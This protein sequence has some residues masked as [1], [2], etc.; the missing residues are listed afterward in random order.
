MSS[1]QSDDARAAVE[2]PT[3]ELPLSKIT[4][5]PEIYGS[6]RKRALICCVSGCKDELMFGILSG[7][8]RT[9][10]R[11]LAK[12]GEML[13]V[14]ERTVGVTR[15]LVTEFDPASLSGAAAKSAVEAFAELEKLGAAGKLLAAARLD[16]TSA[17]SDG[18][19]HRDI[20]GFLALSAGTSVGAARSAMRAARRVK[21]QPAVEA[22]LRHGE[23]SGAQTEAITA[24]VKADPEAEANLLGVAKTAGHR[25]LRRECDRVT[26]AARSRETEAANDERIHRERSLRHRT[27]ADGSGRIEIQGP[28]DRTAQIM[29]GLEPLERELFE[30]NRAAKQLV[31][32]DSVAFDALVELCEHTSDEPDS[33]RADTAPGAKA[34]PAKTRGSR[35][36]AV[37]MVHIS[38]DAYL[39][40]WTVPGEICELEGFGPISVA[41]AYRFASDAF[42]KTVAALGKTEY[43]HQQ[44]NRAPPK[45]RAAALGIPATFETGREM[46]RQGERTNHQ[47]RSP[48][49]VS[50][51]R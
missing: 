41:N 38:Y 37:L 1:D 21:A 7:H 26:A 6:D 3:P 8:D 50:S 4:A 47:D 12:G 27:M 5:I 34:R 42:L 23:L 2:F 33:D 22:A 36:L 9:V 11:Q 13:A 40:G 28:L 35:P 14:L 39:R 17:W 43:T 45:S 10:G 18:G 32:P 31:H 16:E 20:E 25:G 46:R 15:S 29:A 49:S 24:A 30:A 51:P 44:S 19:A 48:P